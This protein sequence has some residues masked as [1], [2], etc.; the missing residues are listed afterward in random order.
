MKKITTIFRNILSILALV[1]A[2]KVSVDS[3]Y[4]RTQESEYSAPYE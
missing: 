3:T 2:A 1:I 4:D